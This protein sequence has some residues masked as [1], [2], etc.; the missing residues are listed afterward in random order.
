M[1]RLILKY[2]TTEDHTH[3]QEYTRV[4]KTTDGTMVYILV[5]IGIAV[6]VIPGIIIFGTIARPIYFKWLILYFN[7]RFTFAIRFICES[8][9]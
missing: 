8:P 9:T 5:G 1:C 2:N 7:E 6:V 4:G 3:Y